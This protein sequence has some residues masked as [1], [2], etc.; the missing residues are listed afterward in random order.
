M[1]LLRRQ[2]H[3]RSV[4]TRDHPKGARST[5]SQ[6]RSWDRFPWREQHTKR[7]ATMRMNSLP[8]VWRLWAVLCVCVLRSAELSDVKSNLSSCASA[9]SC[10]ECTS[11]HSWMPGGPK[12]NHT[13]DA[14]PTNGCMQAR[15]VAGVLRTVCATP[16]GAPR[17]RALVRR[18][19]RIRPN[20]VLN[21]PRHPQTR[22][23]GVLFLTTLRQH[24]LDS[25]QLRR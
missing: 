10:E 21:P 23:F 24:L 2:K 15:G 22:F 25:H 12:P 7:L 17:T 8:R 1:I 3:V 14:Q 5:I 9:S 6:S 4:F 13:P 19:G 18:R 11:K 20:A 16:M